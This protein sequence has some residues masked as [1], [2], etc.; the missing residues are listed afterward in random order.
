MN[1]R[2]K[3]FRQQ[4]LFG[5]GMILLGIIATIVTLELAFALFVSAIGFVLL[6]TKN[7]YFTNSLY[8]EIKEEEKG[9]K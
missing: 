6:F 5:I 3:Y 2:K 7:M 4:K 1:K 9:L 8:F